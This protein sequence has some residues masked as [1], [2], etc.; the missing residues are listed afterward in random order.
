[1]SEYYVANYLELSFKARSPVKEL[2]LF[3][4][5]NRTFRYIVN[6]YT[7]TEGLPEGRS[8]SDTFRVRSDGLVK[9]G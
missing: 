5:K 8:R 1:M 4:K 9:K 2:T 3:L 7:S 6:S